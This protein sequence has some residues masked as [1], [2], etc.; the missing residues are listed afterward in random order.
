MMIVLDGET[1]GRGRRR[2]E[3]RSCGEETED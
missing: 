1:N 3:L 2:G